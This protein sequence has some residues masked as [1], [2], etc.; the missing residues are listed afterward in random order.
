MSLKLAGAALLM[1]TVLV[2]GAQAAAV[3]TVNGVAFPVGLLLGGNQV[4]TSVFGESL[5]TNVGDVS[6]GVGVVTSIRTPTFLQVWGDGQNGSELVFVFDNYK[7]VSITPPG[8]ASTG[9]LLFQGGTINFYTLA[10][11]TPV[12]GFGSI[13]NDIAAAQA[14]T[15]WLSLAAAPL[16]PAGNTLVSTI[17]GGNSL[18]AFAG[19]H[20][21]GFLNVVG[22]PAAP[23]LD[24]QTFANVFDAG[25]F[26]DMTFTTDFSTSSTSGSDFDVS[27]SATLKANAVPEP[28]SISLLGVGLVAL[29]LARRSRR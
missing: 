26:S 9:T 17:P 15:L 29:G 8:P 20:G 27:G 3:V 7:A 19:G 14:G 22:G 4:D 24:T 13:G 1:L 10:A 2:G 12:N 21:E 5:V 11:G 6:R 25:G 28:I 18:T 16:D 23:F